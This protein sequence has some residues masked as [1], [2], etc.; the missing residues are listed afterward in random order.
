MINPVQFVGP[1]NCVHCIQYKYKLRFIASNLGFYAN[2]YRLCLFT[3]MGSTPMPA[4][5]DCVLKIRA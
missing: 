3:R 2:Y 5:G 4:E 1:T